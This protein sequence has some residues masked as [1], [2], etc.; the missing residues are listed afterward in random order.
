[1]INPVHPVPGPDGKNTRT[2]E[3]TENM[4]NRTDIRRECHKGTFQK[5]E[6]LS[7]RGSVRNLNW[8]KEKEDGFEVVSMKAGV[9]GSHGNLYEVKIKIEDDYR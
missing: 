1:M 3:E 8:T 5:G 6:E 7:R 4:L 9:N 2:A